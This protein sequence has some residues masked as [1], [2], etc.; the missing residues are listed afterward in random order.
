MIRIQ[1]IFKETLALFLFIS[2]GILKAQTASSPTLTID[3]LKPIGQY[4]ARDKVVALPGSKFVCDQNNSSKL[5]LDKSIILP[6]NAGGNPYADYNATEQYVI[7]K[8]LPVGYIKGAHSVNQGQ[9]SYSIPIKLPPSTANFSPNLGIIYNSNSIDGLLGIGWDLSTT[10]YIT[11]I[12]KDLYHNNQTAP[13]L[14]NNTDYFTLDG[15]L[16]WG[17]APSFSSDQA[18]RLEYD[19][20]TDVIPLNNY[21][22]FK[23]ITKDGLTLEYGNTNDA[24]LFVSNENDLS[25]PLKYF[26]NRVEDKYG[27]YYTYHYTNNNNEIVLNEIKYTGNS[28]AGINPYNSIKFY[29]D[30]KED[31]SFNFFKGNE[32]K[33]NSIIREIEIFCEG[34]SLR[35]YVPTYSFIENRTYLTKL[36]EYTFDNTHLNPTAFSY[37]APQNPNSQLHYTNIPVNE[38]PLNADYKIGDFNGD[39]KADVLAYT[40]SSIAASSGI[41]NYTG[42]KLYINQNNGTS[43]NLVA[44]ATDLNN[45]QGYSYYGLP[46]TYSPD[47]DGVNAINL[48]GDDKE[49]ALFLE[50]DG[51]NTIY[52]TQLSTGSG[53]TQ[54]FTF[55]IPSGINLMFIDVDGNKIPE[56]IGYHTASNSLYVINFHTNKI[57]IRNIGSA[58]IDPELNAASIGVF[59]PIT[60]LE[61]DGDASQEL[62]VEIN[63]KARVLKFTNY[64]PDANTNGSNFNLTVLATDY[65]LN[66]P[67]NVSFNNIENLY[68]DFNGDGLTD[69]LTRST[70]AFEPEEFFPNSFFIRYNTSKY[71][72]SNQSFYK[73]PSLPAHTFVPGKNMLGKKMIITDLDNDRKSDILVFI[74]NYPQNKTDVFVNYGINIS[75]RVYLGSISDLFFPDN[76]N[77]N[78]FLGQAYPTDGNLIPEFTIGDFDGDGYND[79][80]FK[81]TN[82]GQR[83]I[84]YYHPQITEGKLSKVTNGFN[85]TVK[86]NYKTLAQQNVHTKSA[87]S[88][89]PTAD[90]QYP[91]KV[92][93]KIDAQ[94]ANQNFYEITY[95]Y[96]GAKID[97]RGKGFLGFDKIIETNQL[98]QRK[99]VTTFSLNLFYAERTLENIKQYLLT[100]T[101]NPISEVNYDYEFVHSNGVSATQIGHYNKL[102]KTTQHD[103]VNGQ[104]SVTNY[105]YDNYLNI[106]NTN[107]NINSGLQ[108]NSITHIIDQ[109]LYGNRY[110]G[111]IQSTQNTFNRQNQPQISR[112]NQFEYTANGLLKKIIKNASTA[113][114]NSLEYTYDNNTGLILNET[115]LSN[116]NMPRTSSYNYDSKFRFV[117]KITN[118]LNYQ[119][120]VEFDSKFGN[121]TKT[122]DETNLITKYSY[123]A[124]GRIISLTTP[125]NLTTTIE[126]KWHEPNDDINNDP[127]PILNTLLVS[128]IYSPNKPTTFSYYTATGLNLKNVTEGYNQNYISNRINYNGLGQI[129]DA[130]DNYLIPCNNPALVL[131]SSNSYDNLNRLVNTVVTDG[132]DYI[133]TSLNYNLNSGSMNVTVTSPDGKIKTSTNDATGV[134]TKVQDNSG[135]LEYD[136]Y[137]DGSIKSTKHNG[138]ITNE[139]QYDDCGNIYIE[140]E[141]NNGITVYSIDGFGQLRSKLNDNKIYTYDYDALG[142]ITLLT[143][144]EGAYQ[145][146]YINSGNGLGNIESITAPNATKFKYYYDGL[147]RLNKFDEIIGSTF[148][149]KIEY[150]NYNN[151]IKYTY[152]GGF[153]IAYK[154]NNNGYLS[155]IKNHQNNSLIWSADEID[156]FGNV[157]KYTLGNGIQS[158]NSFNSFGYL[159]NMQAGNV[160]ND[161]YDFNI[162]SGNLNKIT[163]QIK[164]LREEYNYDNLD[165]L[166]QSV[167][168]D[169]FTQTSLPPLTLNYSQNGNIANKSDVGDYKYLMPKPNA[170]QF[171]KNP[172]NVISQIQQDIT[173][174]AFEK[175]HSIIEGDNQAIITYGPTQE[176]VKTDILNTVT[177][178][179][180]SRFYLSNYEKE[181]DGTNTREINYIST[182]TGLNAIHV[183]EN[184]TENTYY[185][186]TNHLG[187]LKTITN[188]NG[189][190]VAEQNFDPWGRRRNPDVWDYSS[191]SNP[192]PNWLYR[193]FTGHEHL[194]QFSL[195]NMNGRMYDPLNGRMLSSD[196]I[197]QELD[198][199]QNHNR[200]SYAL[201]NP[202]KYTDPSGYSFVKNIINSFTNNSSGGDVNIGLNQQLYFDESSSRL[203]TD[204]Y[205]ELKA[206]NRL[207]ASGVSKRFH[208]NS[209]I[210]KTTKSIVFAAQSARTLDEPTATVTEKTEV[211]FTQDVDM[212][213]GD[214]P[215]TSTKNNNPVDT[216]YAGI[217]VV[218]PA[219]ISGQYLDRG[220]YFSAVIWE[221]YAL[222][223]LVTLGEA[224][225]YKVAE[226]LTTNVISKNAVRGV[227]A[228]TSLSK[229]FPNFVPLVTRIGGSA[230]KSEVYP[231]LQ[232]IAKGDWIKVYQG[233]HINGIGT[234]IHF[235]LHKGSG[236]IANPKIKY[237]RQIDKIL[238][239]LGY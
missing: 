33:S 137:S 123:D 9:L 161:E 12:P 18:R 219:L 140:N 172:N 2:Y 224:S 115:L 4:F 143:G 236:Q 108:I 189:T 205:H 201:N 35:K 62:L 220:D 231:A 85:Q 1:N 193:G 200:Y 217:P 95:Q 186:Y 135:I 101:S 68:G 7:D 226:S 111:F 11:R 60:I 132:N 159:T 167:V 22:A 102:V 21:S 104:S 156:N 99:S 84:L 171:V 97:F 25:V 164:S 162:Y 116:N 90:I 204:Y 175:A 71:N 105:T 82:N 177:Q 41:R 96:E 126:N 191:P 124:W 146:N 148:T 32:L 207:K 154:Y 103:Y 187:T 225:K 27:N 52:K 76:V 178:A 147:N 63:S 160:L 74:R 55:T 227:S 125:D 50:N 237:S 87:N 202:L 19:N 233:G 184:N 110:P 79:V 13:I 107:T 118:S 56:A 43:Y 24:K 120:S 92:V 44:S 199:S 3:E 72:S 112:T 181:T 51:G 57:Q 136:Y 170:V 194:P 65:L 10:S 30:I 78:H 228:M 8:N 206:Y 213:G 61:Y 179:S 157:N 129:E 26:I 203:N 158:Q 176:R 81:N 6:I 106:T 218:G 149:T 122:I 17:Q 232:K 238:K 139:Y 165:R 91:M 54:G 130:K 192:L 174:T 210:I 209:V 34:H 211:E 144:I 83:T 229:R 100:N 190:V 230:N 94:D 49:D 119:N 131:T 45:F 23:V 69:N 37:E 234:E 66:S 89:Y 53:F 153:E 145:Y 134:V 185:V 152:P 214:D 121:P 38:L 166:T 39:G 168:T 215:P 14:L 208:K 198:N 15:N 42:W 150:D 80:M 64:N 127:F 29:Y 47:G 141:P 155:Q 221:A 239:D 180:S 188:T 163:D 59:K 88:D 114:F 169:L 222:L 183:K 67:S 138:N 98:T 46:N 109:N 77:Y 117:T 70:E 31:I 93:Q 216:W 195:I 151:P 173:Y 197:L 20:F 36:T 75:N 223:D 182:P 142:R 16:I 113:C 40:Y 235:Y 48:N 58:I 5:Y 128:K 133:N 86:F 196:P 212:G 28:S 73:L